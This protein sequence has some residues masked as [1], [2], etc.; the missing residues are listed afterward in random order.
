MTD[1]LLGLIL[2]T[3][4]AFLFAVSNM[5]VTR[6]MSVK[7]MYAGV[8][9]TILFSS[10]MIFIMSV[11]SGEF[12]RI[13]SLPLYVSFLFMMAGVLN[14]ILGRALNYTGMVILGPSRGS[15]IT[16][17]QSLFAVFFGVLLIAE[18]LSLAAG[19]GVVLA[20]FGTVLVTTGNDRGRRLNGSGL[21]YSLLA[22]IFVGMS[23]VVIRAADLMSPLPL[24]GALISYLTAGCFYFLFN[25]ARTR[26]LR[27]VVSG[28]KVHLLAAAGS[29]SGIA[30][31]AR[32]I[33][34][35]VAP[36]VLV[37][38]IITANPLFTMVLSYLTMRGKEALSL[39]LAAGALLI[40]AGVAVISY[41]LAG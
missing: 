13:A 17:S 29:A 32:F 22:A 8:F 38:P 3:A 20:F 26:S 4:S 5:F 12:L 36:V 34:L 25:L 35:L 7:N 31:S 24:D 16:S 39:R 37:A 9:T 11:A 33:A 15:S 40:I 27:G 2:S 19:I 10:T 23:V 41:A 6:G 28:E 30:Q 1:I 21:I 18:P 14:F